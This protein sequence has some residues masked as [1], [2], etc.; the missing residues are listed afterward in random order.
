V[1]F[2][3]EVAEWFS[4]HAPRG[5]QSEAEGYSRQELLAFNRQWLQLLNTKGFGAPHVPIKWGG[6]GYSPE[7]QI[8][9]YREWAR[10]RAPSLG[11]YDINLFHVPGTLL[12]AG[13]RAQQEK[14][15]REAIDGVLW[16]Q[17]FSEPDAGSDLAS[18]RTTAVRD[19]DYYRVNGQKIWSSHAHES[20]YGL[21]LARTD[22]SAPR[23]HGISYF[24]LDMSSPGLEIR[25]IRQSSGQ[26]EFCELFLDSVMIPAGNRIG[27]EGEGWAVAQ[28][29]LSVERGILALGAIEHI[30]AGVGTLDDLVSR[31]SG[32]YSGERPMYEAEAVVADFAARSVAVRSAAL[33]L[34]SLQQLPGSPDILSSAI[35]VAS[36]EM[37][38]ELTDFGCLFEG[39]DGLADPHLEAQRSPLSGHWLLDWLQSWGRTISAGTN[40]I[41]RNIIA[42]RVL[43]LPREVRG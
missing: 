39:A 40:E 36:S 41:Q 14:Y 25:R 32:D 8:I 43:G 24:I 13:T 2:Q 5:W 31:E 23:H 42:E 22:P 6:G 20:R 18:L 38:Q 17:A 3:Q 9:I 1:V 10:S 19:G 28:R 33:D 15:I 4:E 34:I 16:C 7:E 21:L 37:L 29:T 27:D 35:K 26:A 30:N 11:G 12:R